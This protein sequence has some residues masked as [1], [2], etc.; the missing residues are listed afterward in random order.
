M[1]PKNKNFETD[2]TRLFR[3]RELDEGDERTISHIEEF[4]CSVVQVEKSNSRPGWSYTVGVYDTSSS[5][6]I[7]VAGLPE[8][9]ALFLLNEAAR[10]LRAGTN[11]SDGRHRDMLGEVECEFRPVDPKWAQHLMGWAHWYYDGWDF[12]VLQAVYPEKLGSTKNSHSLLCSLTFPGRL[13]KTISGHRQTLKAASLTGSSP[14]LHTR[15]STCRRRFK[16]GPS[17]SLTF[18]T[19]RTTEHGNSWATACPIRVGSFPASIIQSTTTPA[20]LN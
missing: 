15:E 3:S 2:R 20:S 10:Q 19:T 4:G 5:P 16:T 7:I 17:Q 12:P 11:L 1:P 6:E 18:L 9:T 14:I 8:K 13:S